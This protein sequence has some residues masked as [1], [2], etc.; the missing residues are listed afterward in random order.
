MRHRELVVLLAHK[1]VG[2]SLDSKAA[3]RTFAGR[4]MEVRFQPHS[5]CAT[6]VA[7][8]LKIHCH[9]ER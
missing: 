7:T 9:V 2:I 4:Q 6:K 3:L 1:S 5:L 8:P